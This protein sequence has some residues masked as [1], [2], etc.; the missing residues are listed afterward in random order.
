MSIW[1]ATYFRT[2]DDTQPAERTAVIVAQDEDAASKAAIAGMGHCMLVYVARPVWGAFDA[3]VTA[4]SES[5]GIQAFY[6]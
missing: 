4:I 1:N 3:E 5:G 2:F 6:G